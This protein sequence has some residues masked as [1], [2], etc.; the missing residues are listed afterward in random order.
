MAWIR[1]NRVYEIVRGASRFNTLRKLNENY[2]NRGWQKIGDIKEHDRGYAAL[3][4]KE[5]KR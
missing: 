2:L 3:V 4:Y 5:V 1:E